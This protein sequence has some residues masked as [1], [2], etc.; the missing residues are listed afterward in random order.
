[1]RLKPASSARFFKSVA[2]GSNTLF[3]AKVVMCHVADRL[4]GP[5]FKLMAFCRSVD[6]VHAQ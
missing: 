1:M 6:W 4:I 5:D 2:L 3:V